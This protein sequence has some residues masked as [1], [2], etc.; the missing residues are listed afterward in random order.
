MSWALNKVALITGSTSGIGREVAVHFARLGARVVVSGRNQE[1]LQ[2]VTSQSDAASPNGN[3]ALPIQADV[4]SRDSLKN[5]V[6]T[7]VKELGQIDVLVN[8]AGIAITTKRGVFDSNL[9]SIYDD[10]MATNAASV[11]YMCHLAAPHLVKTQGTIVNVSSVAGK[12]AFP[13]NGPYCM[14]KAAVD[15]LTQV[16]ALELGAKG[17]RVN[18]VNPGV[19]ETEIFARSGMNEQQIET[20]KKIN[21][22]MTPLGRVGTPKDI[23]DLIEFLASPRSSW[24]TGQN[25]MID[26]GISA[27][28]GGIAVKKSK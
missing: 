3:K 15:I 16:L 21:A 28:P 19:V 17:V 11:L 14:S 18:S 23:A 25:V 4:T 13:L 6:D 22:D 10:I 5:L 2:Q 1:R 20:F 12:K 9:M 24:I 8:N 7:T 26:G 27:G